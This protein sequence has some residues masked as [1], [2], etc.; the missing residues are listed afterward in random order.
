M[1]L[2]MHFDGPMTD[3]EFT[4]FEQQLPDMSDDDDAGY[5]AFFELLSLEGTMFSDGCA[6]C[7]FQAENGSRAAHLARAEL[8]RRA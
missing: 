8:H 3:D 5:L 1:T 6:V 7:V 2:E 4:V